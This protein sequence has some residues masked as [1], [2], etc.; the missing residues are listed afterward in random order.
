MSGAKYYK[1]LAND[2]PVY[3]TGNYNLAGGWQSCIEGELKACVN[4]YH[5]MTADQVSSWCGDGLIEI[6]PQDIE[7]A[8]DDKCVCRSW[9]MVRR[10][11]WTRADMVDYAKWCAGRAKGYVDA[12]DAAAARCADARKSERA[13][14][15]EWIETKI[16]EKL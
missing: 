13:A 3:G 1:W 8:Q 5:V 11:K 14:Q 16:G 6:E 10:L 7:I 12:A 15:R 2:K 4:G 9:R